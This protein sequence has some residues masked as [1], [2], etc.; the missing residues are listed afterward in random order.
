MDDELRRID[1]HIEQI[2]GEWCA[3]HKSGRELARSPEKQL[4][5]DYLSEVIPTSKRTKK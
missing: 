3:F 2:D 4:L 5:L 1:I